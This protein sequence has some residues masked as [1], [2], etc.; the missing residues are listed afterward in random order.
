MP[1]RLAFVVFLVFASAAAAQQ[2]YRWTDEKG[3]VHITDTPPPA[4]A[5]GVQ[6]AGTGAASG[7]A[8]SQQPYEL[9]LAVKDY[10]VTLYTSPG[11]KGPCDAARALLNK[12][13]VP[14]KEV[15]VWDEPSNEELKRV[16]GAN[17]VP[18]LVV[19]RSVHRGYEP[20]AY[21]ALLDSGRYPRTGLLPPRSQAAPP[22]PESY[23]SAARPSAS[24]AP[25]REAPARG[26]YAPRPAGN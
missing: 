17:D 2:L 23:D 21:Q 20:S 15:Q 14:F 24:A 6:S 19:G 1:L 5:R 3:R 18:T 10:P 25:E 12:R 11:C 16:S 26:P 22:P 4:S 13:A 9:T 8:E 7:A